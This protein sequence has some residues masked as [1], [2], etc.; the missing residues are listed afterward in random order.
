MEEHTY[1]DL[2]HRQDICWCIPI[3]T[4]HEDNADVDDADDHHLDN[5]NDHGHH[6]HVM[7]IIRQPWQSWW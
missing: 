7:I 6:H 5:D 2:S 1:H 3:I 4:A